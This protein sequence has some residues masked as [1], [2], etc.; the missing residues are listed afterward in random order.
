MKSKRTIYKQLKKLK[1]SESTYILCESNR[2]AVIQALNWVLKDA[3][4]SPHRNFELMELMFDE[5]KKHRND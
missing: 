2:L 1:N 3:H 4:L 5:S